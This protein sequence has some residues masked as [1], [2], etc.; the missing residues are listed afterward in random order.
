MVEYTQNLARLERKIG[1]DFKDKSLLVRAL[2]HSSYGDG[3]RKYAHFE[4]L[5]FLGDRVLNLMTAEA[6]F[7]AKDLDEGQM[8][9]KLNSLVRKETCAD[10]ARNID[11][12][13]A[14][15]LSASEDKQGGRNKTS[16]LGDACEAL[17]AA[18][19]IDGGMTAAQT[20]FELFWMDKVSGTLSQSLKDPKTVLQ[21]LSVIRG[22]GTPRYQLVKR[23]GPDHNP[24]F[25]VE[26]SLETGAKALGQGHSKKHAERDAAKSLISSL[27]N[28]VTAS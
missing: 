3:K 26:V 15:F 25:H 11:L 13:Q 6:L 10:V 18:L 17:I 9:R 28:M 7:Q 8:A 20:F 5:E 23:E 2:T 22:M 21:E 19:Y 4:R 14:L 1:Y 16:I 12:G 24:H 27:V